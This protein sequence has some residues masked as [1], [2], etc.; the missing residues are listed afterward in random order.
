[1]E[2]SACL[3]VKNIGKPCAG[4][5]H[6]RFDEGGLAKAAMVWLFRHRQT[7][8][9]GTDKQSLK[10][11]QPVPYSTPVTLLKYEKL[12]FLDATPKGLDPKDLVLFEIFHGFHLKM[13]L[14]IPLTQPFPR[15]G[16]D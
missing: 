3:T 15:W 16:E 5:P 7:K 13:S 1:M 8:G 14:E 2:E 12:P 11:Q 9:T 6:A 4:K 10:R